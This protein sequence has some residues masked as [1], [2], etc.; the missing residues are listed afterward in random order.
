MLLLPFYDVFDEQR[1]FAPATSQKVVELDGERLAVTICEDAWNDKNF[2][3]ES[4]LSGRSHR[5]PH[6][7][8]AQRC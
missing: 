3:A 4:P 7:P 8:A 6:A 1:Y 5:R 2:L